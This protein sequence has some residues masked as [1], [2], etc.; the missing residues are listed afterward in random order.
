MPSPRARSSRLSTWPFVVAVLAVLVY[1]LS[2]RIPTRVTAFLLPATTAILF[3]AVWQFSCEWTSYELHNSD[4]TTRMIRITPGPWDTAMGMSQMFAD[5]KIFKYTIAS[6]YRVACG[7][8]LACLVGIPLGLWAGWSTRAFQGLN[9]LIQSLRPISP[10]AWIS[11]AILWFGVKDA[12]AIFLI[13][14]AA[15]FPIVTS[16]VSAVRSIPAVYIRSAQNFGLGGFELVRRVVF[17]A[18]LPQIVTSMRLAMGI[19]WMVVVAAEMIAVD[20]GLGY[21]IVDGRNANNYERV[22]GAMVCI[23]IVGIALDWSVR[24]LERLDEVRWGFSKLT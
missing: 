6:L 23:G 7:F 15:F 12:S 13:F 2:G 9:P 20:S 5:G 8:T 3:V 24:R 19:A 18:A 14:M 1:A 4:G 10:I 17:P 16:T 22:C 21:L 11:I